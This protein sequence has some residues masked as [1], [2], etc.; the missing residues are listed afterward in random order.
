MRDGGRF[1]HRL[2]A[3]YSIVSRNLLGLRFNFVAKLN[4]PAGAS[5]LR[6]QDAPSLRP[7][8]LRV[9]GLHLERELAGCVL[10]SFLPSDCAFVYKHFSLLLS[11]RVRKPDSLSL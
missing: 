9:L 2:G 10:A 1:D 7:R 4:A 11:K 8:F 5:S 6:G 3:L